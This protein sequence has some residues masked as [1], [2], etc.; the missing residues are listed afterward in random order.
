M[1]EV[2]NHNPDRASG[3]RAVEKQFDTTIS[4][5]PAPLEEVI[6][7]VRPS[8]PQ[9][10]DVSDYFDRFGATDSPAEA[11]SGKL[12]AL[13]RGVR[14]VFASRNLAHYIMKPCSRAAGS[15]PTS[16]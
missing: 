1:T 7:L 5:G 12:A 8:Q 16:P 2:A 10:I 6:S 14:Y 9:V 11:T 15:D 4:D 13:T 3:R